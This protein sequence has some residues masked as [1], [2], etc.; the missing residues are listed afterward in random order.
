MNRPFNKELASSGE[1]GKL[2]TSPRALRAAGMGVAGLSINGRANVR[3]LVS[4]GGKRGTLVTSGARGRRRTI[5][6]AQQKRMNIG[7]GKF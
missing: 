4:G 3:P 1:R 7:F 6:T 5:T 2:G